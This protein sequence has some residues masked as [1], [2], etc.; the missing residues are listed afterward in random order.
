[1]PLVTR[2][3]TL[4]WDEASIQPKYEMLPSG[5]FCGLPTVPLNTKCTEVN[6]NVNSAIFEEESDD[7]S[8]CSIDDL[9]I[10]TIEDS[11][12]RSLVQKDTVVTSKKTTKKL[13]DV[14]ITSG[15]EGNDIVDGKC[16]STHICVFQLRGTNER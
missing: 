12:D 3:C 5:E 4:A 8:V 1:M 11:V 10:N 6:D 7:E 9:E 2:D 13:V 16:L 15:A 14:E